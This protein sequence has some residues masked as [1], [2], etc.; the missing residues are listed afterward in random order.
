MFANFEKRLLQLALKFPD[1]PPSFRRGSEVCGAWTVIERTSHELLLEWSVKGVSGATWFYLPEN[2]NI[3]VYGNSITYPKGWIRYEEKVYQA[4]PGKNLTLKAFG[5]LRN[6]K[7]SLVER[8]R[9]AMID[10]FLAGVTS[11]H[12]VYSKL[13]LYST[14]KKV[15][16][17][18]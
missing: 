11:V 3:L 1:K 16:S 15:T 9:F 13:L 5:H 10:L 18:L 17:E 7:L 12:Q 14:L 2:E 8:V 6:D 4:Q